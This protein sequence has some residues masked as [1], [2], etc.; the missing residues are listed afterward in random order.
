MGRHGD[1]MYKQRP[2]QE[3]VLDATK[4]LAAISS[5]HGTFNELDGFWCARRAVSL[6]HISYVHAGE[7]RRLEGESEG[8]VLRQNVQ[9]LGVALKLRF[10]G[11]ILDS[12]RESLDPE[13]DVQPEPC[14][15]P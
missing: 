12:S 14:P 10:L 6:C 13:P 4:H 3:S 7:W 15:Y 11:S 5:G 8:D 2:E 9:L 1:E